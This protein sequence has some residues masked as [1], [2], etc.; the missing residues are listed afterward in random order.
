MGE[1]LDCSLGFLS[2][3]GDSNSMVLFLLIIYCSF[4][5]III[6]LPIVSFDYSFSLLEI[7]EFSPFNIYLW[8][9]F[10]D[11]SFTKY[12]C[13]C[14]FRNDVFDCFISLLGSLTWSSLLCFSLSLLS[15]LLLSD[16]ESE[17]YSSSYIT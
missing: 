2:L 3:V 14:W 1:L 15:S 13:Y 6:L 5:F 10:D 11:Y 17:S 8:I 4:F 16:M 9:G 12:S 7:D